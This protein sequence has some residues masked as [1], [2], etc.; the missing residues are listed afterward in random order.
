MKKIGLIGGVGPESTIEYYKQIINRFQ[1]RQKTKSYPQFIIHSVDMTTMLDYAFSDQ[2]EELV[3]FFAEN[4][5]V[6][7]KAGVECAAI[8]ANTPH[9]IFD[10]LA[11]KVNLP[12]IS[13][14]EETCK[15]INKRGMKR[16]GLFGTKTTMTNEFYPNVAKKYG[17]EITIPEISKQDY[18]HSKYMS[19]FVFNRTSPQTKQNLIQIVRE[20]QERDSIEGLILGGTELPSILNQSDFD[21]IEILDTT[22]IHVESIVDKMIEE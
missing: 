6:L 7:E 2:L 17:I 12:L 9:I 15:E 10:Q 4:I 5:E 20:L 8:A 21:D 3:D 18:I 14:V 11:A 19:D 22:K 13:I 1:E 16:V